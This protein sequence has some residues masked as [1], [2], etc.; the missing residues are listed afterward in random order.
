MKLSIDSGAQPMKR[1]LLSC[2]VILLAQVA[3]AQDATPA[4]GATPEAGAARTPADICASAVPAQNPTTRQF[5]HPDQVLQPGVDYRAVFCT[6]VGPVYVDLFEKYAPQTVNSF[7]F[8]AQQGYFNNTTFHR[9]LQ[10]YIA[11]GGDPTG[12]GA[13]DPGYSTPDEFVGFLNFDKP[14]WLAMANAGPNTNG[15][16]FF[17]TTA[18]TPTLN[19]HYTIFG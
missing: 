7:V 11:Q 14:G 9:V 8:L 1:F 4:A 19:Y 18:P 3:L 15:S 12:T 16:Q 2:L 6:D 17:I 10:G 13:G 5:S